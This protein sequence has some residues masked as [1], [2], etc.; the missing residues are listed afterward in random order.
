MMLAYTAY[1]DASGKQDH[2]ETV[3]AGIVSP[4]HVWE[5]YEV[6]W[7]LALCQFDVPYFHM[8]E[9]TASQGPYTAARW[10]S[11]GYRARFLGTLAVIVKSATLMTVARVLKHSL[12][13]EVNKEYEL[14]TRFNPYVICSLDCA[15]QRSPKTGQ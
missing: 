11:E 15:P 14:D 8:K 3:V 6:D 13:A 9:F 2:P 4:V 12:F 1:F 5:R 7:R 10:K